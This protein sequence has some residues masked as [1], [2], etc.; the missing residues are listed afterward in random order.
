MARK[1]VSIENTNFIWDTNFSGDPKKDKYGSSMRQANIVIPDHMMARDMIDEGFNIKITRPKD[2]EEEGFV[3][4]YYVK[5]AVNYDVNWPP[6]IYLV[7][8]DNEPVLLDEVSIAEL[9]RIRVKNVNAVLSSREWA[10]GQFS[11][12]VKTM[13]VEQG[14]DNDPFAARYA[15]R[16]RE[17]DEE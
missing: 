11:L 13:Y 1:M 17:Y 2:G 14:L 9:D 8:G 6:K 7:V 5:I 4:R 12:Y 16:N 10:P 15:R 3:P